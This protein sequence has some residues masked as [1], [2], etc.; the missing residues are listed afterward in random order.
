M[1]KLIYK[2]NT[3]L[4]GLTLFDEIFDE[5]FKNDRYYPTQQQQNIS[6]TDDTVTITMDVPGFKKS[7]LSINYENETIQIT[8]KKDDNGNRPCVTKSYQISNIDIKKSVA[9]LEDGVLTLTLEKTAKCKKQQLKI[10]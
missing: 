3:L 9:N 5:F 4:G 10:S 1:T 6:E 2:P 8:A 7:E